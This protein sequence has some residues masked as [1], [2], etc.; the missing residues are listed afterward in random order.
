MVDQI[1]FPYIQAK[2]FHSVL[3]LLLYYDVTQWP[4][5]SYPRVTANRSDLTLQGGP[6]SHDTWKPRRATHVNCS[7]NYPEV[8][9]KPANT[10]MMSPAR[11]NTRWTRGPLH[12]PSTLPS[13]AGRD[14]DSDAIKVISLPVST[15]SYFR[16]VVSTVQTRSTMPTTVWSS[17]DTGGGLLSIHFISRTNSSPPGLHFNFL[18]DSFSNHI[19]TSNKILILASDRNHS[20]STEI[21]LSRAFLTTPA[22]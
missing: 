18:I 11:A 10:R 6:N 8:W 7:H 20:T 19:A 13:T 12:H 15:T 17:I 1:I 5:L 16:H 3:I 21:L 22:Y 2:H 4:R 14:S 9:I